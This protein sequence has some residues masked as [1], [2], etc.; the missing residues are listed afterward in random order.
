MGFTRLRREGTVFWLEDIVIS[1]GKRSSGL[2]TQFLTS[3]EEYVKD[4]DS[5][6]LYIPVYVG[7]QSAID[8]Y[9]KNGYDILNMIEVRKDFKRKSMEKKIDLLGHEFYLG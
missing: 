6:S 4:N 3:I 5:V 2:G 1:E 8:F 9:Y 7:N